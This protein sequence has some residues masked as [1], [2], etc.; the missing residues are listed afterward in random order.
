MSWRTKLRGKPPPAPAER[1]NDP[2]KSR[3]RALWSGI[4]AACTPAASL[5]IAAGLVRAL[6]PKEYGF[7]VIALAVSGLSAAI[8]PAIIATTT[9]F[10]SDANGRGANSTEFARILTGS[11]IVVA[12][13]GAFLVG[14]TVIFGQPLSELI[15]G[16]ITATAA[17]N[18]RTVLLLA[19]TSICVQQFDGVFAAAL[20]GL[21]QFKWQAIM[22][23]CVRSVLASAVTTIGWATRDARL[24]LAA[25]CCVCG[26]SAILRAVV[27]R[28]CLD[29][30]RIFSCPTREDFSKLM[31]FGGWMWLN[32]A[33]TVAYSSVDR[34]VVGRVVGAAAAAEFNICVQLSQLVH[35][36]PASLLSFSYPV[37]SRMGAQ[38]ISNLDAIRHLYWRYLL[39][40]SGIGLLL[41]V[42]VVIFRHRILNFIGGGVFRQQ[43]DTAFIL[44]VV[45]FLIL[46]FNVVP[47]CLS[48]G[49]GR[50]RSVSLI[51]SLSMMMSILLT[52]F[53]TPSLGF[54]GAALSRLAY[55]VGAL[56]L[57]FLA[58]RLMH[59]E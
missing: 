48:L 45:G 40:A 49:V 26:A 50:P 6:G 10:V 3:K 22:E 38:K 36:L 37:F 13:I 34:I 54:L 14:V 56:A 58:Y 2:G 21:E 12:A 59:S 5:V 35:F 46:S 1:M 17:P 16:S 24:V 20:K 32:A 47:Y 52:S 11:L 44:L 31:N 28:R 39:A 4:D 41:A 55:G 8:N 15:F 51:T 33:A 43:D 27:V 57:F 9:K 29:G 18:V 7:I 53:L 25:Y 42:V 19:V 23:L 30:I